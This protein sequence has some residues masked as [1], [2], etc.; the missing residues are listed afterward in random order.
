MEIPAYRLGT[1][2]VEGTSHPVAVAGESMINLAEAL[3]VDGPDAL[4]CAFADWENARGKIEAAVAE[5]AQVI[6]PGEAEIQTPLM[7]PDKVICA[8]ANYYDHVAEVGIENIKERMKTPYFFFK[9]AKT[10]LVGPGET[11]DYPVGSKAFDW[12]IELAVIIGK[13]SKG[14]SLEDAPGIIAGYALSI[15]LTARDLQLSAPDFFQIDWYAGKAQ[16]TSCPL[17]P[18]ITP[19]HLLPD[20]QDLVL[21]LTVNG[22]QKQHASTSGMIFSIAELVSEA[23]KFVTLEPGDIILTGSPAGVGKASNTYLQRGDRL[24]ASSPDLGRLELTVRQ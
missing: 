23:T 6:P 24:V 4:L 1:V 20:P 15:D 2:S 11:I 10:T 12:E 7:Y 21:D 5:A 18:F 8:G 16:D 22:E 3:G 9:P 14:V 13:R 19:A 17:G